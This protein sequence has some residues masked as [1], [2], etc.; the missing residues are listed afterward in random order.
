M[1][2][3]VEQSSVLCKHKVAQYGIY[4]RECRQ[5]NS[6]IDLME[7]ELKEELLLQLTVS[8]LATSS[9]QCECI[10]VHTFS[11]HLT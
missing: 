11:M 2:L 5:R 9:C 4:K 7:T 3:K 6:C 10:Q 1:Q 8:Y